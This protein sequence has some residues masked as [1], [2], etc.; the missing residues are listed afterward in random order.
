MIQTDPMRLR[1]ILLNLLGNAVK[2]TR[3]GKI[4]IRVSDEAG[5]AANILLRIDVI[6]SGVGMA[7]A[8]LSRLF[9]PFTQGDESITRKFGGTGLG[10]TISRRLAKLLNGDI[11]VA[12]EVG[13]GSTFTVRI[14]GGPSAAVEMLQDLSEAT[15]PVVTGQ[16][17][18]HDIV[19]CGRILLA[20]DG[21]DNQRL[22]RMQLRDA[23]A[24]VFGAEDGQM[25]IDLAT[26]QAFDLILMDMQ[27]PVVDGYA[28]TAELRRRGLKLP[29]IAL[30]AYAMS[31][32][33]GKCL[34]CGCDDYLSKPVKEETLLKTVSRYLGNAP[35]TAP[36]EAARGAVAV[37]GPPRQTAEG[38]GAIRSRLAD[39]PRMQRII[40][41]FV[42]GLPG[43]VRRMNDLLKRND[44]AAL[45][46]LVHQLRGASGGYGFDAVTEPATRVEESIKGGQ[47]LESVAGEMK[48]LIEVIRRID[49]Y[50]ESEAS[51]AAK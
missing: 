41:E 45:E 33:R 9:R 36:D 23:G 38:S 31:E 14:D 29:I 25:A 20:E 49:G 5:G 24:V 44:L 48:S 21:Q 8:L 19:L 42:E 6:D 3:S 17:S 28:A 50:D 39:D 22:L 16:A 34:A 30:T 11:S 37:S 4:D 32:D 18:H 15:L 27:M 10:L 35:S 43:E 46:K 51:V 40:H 1:Q 2:F 26:T 7:P 12:S 47:A 13:I